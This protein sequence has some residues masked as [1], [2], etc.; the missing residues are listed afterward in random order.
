MRREISIT[1]RRPVA[2]EKKSIRRGS[3]RTCSHLDYEKGSAAASLGRVPE[4]ARA[5][6]QAGRGKYGKYREH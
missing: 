4:D 3:T 2:T 6:G 1:L 5:I